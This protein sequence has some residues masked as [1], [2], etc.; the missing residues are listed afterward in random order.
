MSLFTPHIYGPKFSSQMLDGFSHDNI[1]KIKL[2][3]KMDITDL[4]LFYFNLGKGHYFVLR[5]FNKAR[6]F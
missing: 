2:N 6:F 3:V 1:V 4:I 5:F